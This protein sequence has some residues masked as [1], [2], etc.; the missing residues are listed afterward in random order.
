[1]GGFEFDL[2]ESKKIIS[3]ESILYMLFIDCL[4]VWLKIKF[5]SDAK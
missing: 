5:I 3:P 4:L 2:R 1:M